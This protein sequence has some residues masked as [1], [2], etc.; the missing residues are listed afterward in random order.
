MKKWISN[1]LNPATDLPKLEITIQAASEAINTQE[2]LEALLF[3][4]KSAV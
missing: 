3:Y 2:L 4:E 1:L